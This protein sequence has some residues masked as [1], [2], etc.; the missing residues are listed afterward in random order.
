MVVYYLV[1]LDSFYMFKMKNIILIVI[2]VLFF[3]FVYILVQSM[4]FVC[5]GDFIVFVEMGILEYGSGVEE[6]S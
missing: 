6:W 1:C 3:M 5:I 2:W 4:V